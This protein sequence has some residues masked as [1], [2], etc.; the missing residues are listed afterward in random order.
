MSDTPA[1]SP[2]T[3]LNEDEQLFR[4][5]VRDFAKQSIGPLVRQMDEEQHFAPDLLPQLFKL[6]LMGIEIPMNYGGSGGTFF[7]S[8]SCC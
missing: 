2:L 5:T 7:R 4:S 8:H 1:A 6:G 3:L